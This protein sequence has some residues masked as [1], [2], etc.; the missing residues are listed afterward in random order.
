MRL[1]NRTITTP[2]PRL[3]H[4]YAS[5]APF[6]GT[7]SFSLRVPLLQHFGRPAVRG[8][9]RVYENHRKAYLM[10][11]DLMYITRSEIR[12]SLPLSS[13]ALIRGSPT[14]SSSI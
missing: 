14:R 3:C 13:A 11:E 4:E 6:D 1:D 2:V 12:V 10:L 8:V 9:A 5:V 7:S